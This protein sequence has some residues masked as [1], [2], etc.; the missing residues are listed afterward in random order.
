MAGLGRNAGS[1]LTL[2]NSGIFEKHT[3][4]RFAK[5]RAVENRIYVLEQK[6]EELYCYH[7]VDSS[8]LDVKQ[9]IRHWL[10]NED[11]K[12]LIK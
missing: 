3:Q 5:I 4:L 2:R 12:K 7:V 1:N 8:S 11:V 9:I 10:S 6:L